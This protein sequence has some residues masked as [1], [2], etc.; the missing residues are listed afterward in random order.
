MYGHY[1]HFIS[2]RRFFVSMILVS[3]YLTVRDRA[4]KIYTSTMNNLGGGYVSSCRWVRGVVCVAFR[5][6]LCFQ[7]YLLTSTASSVRADGLLLMK[8]VI[9]D[10]DK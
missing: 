2:F 5:L 1:C 7:Q 4:K 10:R 8:Y 9:Q 3:C 6:C